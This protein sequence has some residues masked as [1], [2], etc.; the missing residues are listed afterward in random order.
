LIAA[1]SV[2]AVATQARMSHYSQFRI[3]NLLRVLQ[4]SE[5]LHQR[6]PLTV[7]QYADSID[8]G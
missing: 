5:E 4:P 1:T 3:Y 7:H 2:V 6:R 8:L